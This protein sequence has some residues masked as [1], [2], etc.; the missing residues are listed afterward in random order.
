MAKSIDFLNFEFTQVQKGQGFNTGSI[1]PKTTTK[2]LVLDKVELS[3]NARNFTKLYEPIIKQKAVESIEKLVKNVKQNQEKFEPLERLIKLEDNQ[4]KNYKTYTENLGFVEKE[5]ISSKENIKLIE[6]SLSKGIKE[7]EGFG[8]ETIYQEG[9]EGANFL[10]QDTPAVLRYG[11]NTESKA[12]DDIVGSCIEKGILHPYEET[13]FIEALNYLKE[14]ENA[15]NYINMK[16]TTYYPNNVIL[17]DIFDRS[18]GFINKGNNQTHTIALWKKKDNEVVLIDPSN[19]EFS[20]YLSNI[21]KFTPIEP[22]KKILYGSGGCE[23][24]YSNY[25]DSKPK[26]RDC[27]DIA[28][29]V[30]FELND[31]QKECLTLDK[32]TDNMLL[33]LSNQK[34]IAPHMYLVQNEFVRTL[35]STSKNTRAIALYTLNQALT[36]K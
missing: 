18:S 32:I 29:K 11:L 9:I 20:K 28:V 16:N 13:L 34:A 31:Q 35:Q 25:Y 8:F 30:A 27:I 6:N 26:P 14:V 3:E 21:F 1:T 17:V 24:G 23:T 10:N 12:L 7:F 4:S 22:T 2:K 33:Q 15:E 19:V 36:K 5:V